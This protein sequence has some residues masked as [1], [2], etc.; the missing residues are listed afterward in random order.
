[1][2][3]FLPFL[4]NPLSLLPFTTVC[5]KEKEGPIGTG[6]SFVTICHQDARRF[7]LRK[8]GGRASWAHHM[9]CNPKNQENQHIAAQFP[10]TAVDKG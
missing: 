9:N 3:F 7:S 4:F 2:E 1:M 8:E 6:L 5:W 10:D